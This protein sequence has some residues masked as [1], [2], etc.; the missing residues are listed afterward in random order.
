MPY[1]MIWEPK[2][3]HRRYYG[4]TNDQEIF[5][6]TIITE[7]SERFDA[8]RY[9]LIDFLAIESLVSTNPAFIPEISAIDSA[10]AKTN[11]CIKLAVVTEHPEIWKLAEAYRAHPLC[12]YPLEIFTSLADARAWVAVELPRE[13]RIKQMTDRVRRMR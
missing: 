12:S 3:V 13:Y 8:L 6:S 1:E 2:G 4:H 11:P 9:I 7:G 10:A 5:E